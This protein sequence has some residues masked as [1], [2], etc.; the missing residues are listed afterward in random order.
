MQYKTYKTY[1]V[2]MNYIFYIPFCQEK[3]NF[4]KIILDKSKYWYYN[5]AYK[6]GRFNKYKKKGSKKHGLLFQRGIAH[7]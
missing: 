7:I 4:F 6:T 5:K 3:I 1:M 2:N